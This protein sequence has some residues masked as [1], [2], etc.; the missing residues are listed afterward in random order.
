LALRLEARRALGAG[1]FAAD[2]FAGT[3][4]FA[5]AVR[6]GLAIGFDFAGSAGVEPDLE[7]EPVIGVLRGLAGDGD[8]GAALGGVAR[9]R[10]LVVPGAFLAVEGCLTAEGFAD[11]TAGF[12]AAVDLGFLGGTADVFPE[13]GLGFISPS[14]LTGLVRTDKG[15]FR[16]PSNSAQR[17][18]RQKAG[19]KRCGRVAS[20]RAR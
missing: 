7:E 10:P 4:G 19:A 12:A 1:A 11:R 20:N 16:G 3:R 2:G 17:E 9:V 14:A 13:R 5:G 6:V 18:S 15:R 8:L